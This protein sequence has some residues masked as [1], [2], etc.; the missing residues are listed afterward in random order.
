MKTYKVS[1]VYKSF[2]DKEVVVKASSKKQA[3]VKVLDNIQEDIIITNVREIKEKKKKSY[4]YQIEVSYPGREKP[5]LRHRYNV[6]A[7]DAYDA[8]KIIAKKHYGENI[9][10]AL[11][12]ENYV[13]FPKSNLRMKVKKLVKTENEI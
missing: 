7:M 12:Y 5:A 4:V 2:P 13:V 10:D 8:V 3:R 9:K 11:F 1:I 6:R